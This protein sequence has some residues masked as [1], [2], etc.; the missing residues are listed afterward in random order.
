MFNTFNMNIQ[1]IAVGK[2]KEKY[3]QQAA[4]EYVKRLSAWVK[5]DIIELKEEKF[6]KKS[7]PLV[8][9][10][11]EAKKILKI[12]PKPC[13][14]VIL[15]QKGEEF[16]SIQ[17]AEKIDKQWFKQN[18]QVTLLIGGPLGLDEKILK[19]ANV[20]WSLSKLTFTHQ[21]VRITMLEQIYRAFCIIKNKRYH[22]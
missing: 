16:D 7:N 22:Y 17:L 20:V 3:L 9:K 10:Q 15:D 5:V 12:L 13:F 19:K 6:D 11:K 1:I 2:L 14:L 4:A 21:M 18:L 8:I